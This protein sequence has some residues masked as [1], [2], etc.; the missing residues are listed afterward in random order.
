MSAATEDLDSVQDAS[1]DLFQY[2]IYSCDNP[3]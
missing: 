1:R 3:R 2:V